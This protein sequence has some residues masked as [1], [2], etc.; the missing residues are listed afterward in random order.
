MFI[1]SLVVGA[2]WN[3][4]KMLKFENRETWKLE[5]GYPNWSLR[6]G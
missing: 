1:F 5:I 4:G 6:F 2:E 3:F